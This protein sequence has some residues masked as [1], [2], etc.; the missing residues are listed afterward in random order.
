MA[1]VDRAKRV[2]LATI[3][4]A[5]ESKSTS[6]EDIGRQW[7]TYGQRISGREYARMIEVSVERWIEIQPVG[8]HVAAVCFC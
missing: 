1:E 8:G 3:S 4:N 7:L 2:T 6:A 5:L